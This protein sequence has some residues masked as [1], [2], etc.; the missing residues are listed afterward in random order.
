MA[1]TKINPIK[2]LLICLATAVVVGLTAGYFYRPLESSLQKTASL[3]IMGF[4]LALLVIYAVLTFRY[5]RVEKRGSWQFFQVLTL[6]AATGLAVQLSG[7]LASPLVLLY[8]LLIVLSIFRSDKW[9]AVPL[10]SILLIELGSSFLGG[11]WRQELLPGM[12]ITAALTLLYVIS[13]VITR[14][15]RSSGAGGQP[16][17]SFDEPVIVQKDLKED[18]ASL[19]SLIQAAMST[20]TS[21]IFRADNPTGTLNMMAFKS[22][23][24]EV[25]K[26]ASLEIR[27]SLLGWAARERQGLLYASYERDSRDLGYYRKSEEVRSVLSVPVLQESEVIGVLVVDSE[28][29]GAFNE[30]DKILLAGFA[31]EAAKLVHFHQSH[32]ALGLEKDRLQ[33]WNSRLEL[34][35]SRLKINDVIKIIQELIPRLVP[36]DHIVLLE[37]L[38]EPGKARVLLSDP[39]NA[40]YPAPGTEIDIAGS[41]SEQAVNLKEWRSVDDFYRRSIGINRFSEDERP[42]HGFR[43]VLAAPLL[44]EDVCHYVLV[45]ESRQPKAFEADRDTIHI[46]AGQFSLALKSA[47]MYEEKETLAIRDGLTGLANHRRFQEYLE[48]TIA[49]AGSQPVGI[50]LFDID[51]F[52]KLNDNY[53]HP[54]G[55]AVLK[56]VAARLKRSISSFDFVARYGGEEFIAVW[57]GR[58]D[59]EAAQLAEQVRLAIEGEKFQTTAGDL[60]VTVSLGVASY[61]QDAKKKAELIKAADEALYAAK[62]GGRNRVVRFAA[63]EKDPG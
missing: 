9:K 38:S 24:A 40:G 31:E 3:M 51:F 18:L 17:M 60:P 47:A 26:D 61:P 36:C 48:E 34:M 10:A 63:M 23:S 15:G 53:G 41:L 54:I 43:S 21:A 30:N 57:P 45:L 11:R 37:V 22:Y 39:A 29:A 56:E 7:A 6:T 13:L 50:A 49:K 46:I 5:W 19:C 32:S 4:C 8:G 14:R 1:Q 25:I 52:K 16:A 27:S 33:Q 44:Y 62:K 58:N 2:V 12:T 59:K 42:D 20:K 35:A 55:D 28:Q